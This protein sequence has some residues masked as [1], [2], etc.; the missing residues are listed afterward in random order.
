MRKNDYEVVNSRGE[1]VSSGAVPPQMLSQLRSCKLAIRQVP[2]PKNALGYIKV[3]FPNQYNVYLHGTPAQSLFA[4]SRRDFSHGC[5]RVEKPEE[6]AQWVL[7]DQREWNLERI[8]EAEHWVRPLQVNLNKPIP[9][10][11]VYG[12]AV[13]RADG[14]VCFFDD[15]YGHDALLEDLLSKGYPYSEW[16]PTSVSRGRRLRE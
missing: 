6:L 13:V 7:R 8:R 10:L 3:M 15:I 14:E 11:I 9:V 2:G 4:K 16:K 5:I 12:T 1:I